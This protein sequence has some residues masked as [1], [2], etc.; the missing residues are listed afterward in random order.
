M[1]TAMR[2]RAKTPVFSIGQLESLRQDRD[3]D[4]A[5]ETPGVEV[6]A[7]QYRALLESRMS[8][9][10]DSH[11][12]PPP[13]R[14][15]E[16]AGVETRRNSAGELQLDKTTGLLPDGSPASDGT[17]VAFDEETVYFKPISFSPEPPSPTHTHE[18][19]P[20]LSPSTSQPDNLSLQIC[21]D[22]LTRELASGMTE[23]P[24][25]NGSD[26]LALQIW[27][28]IEAYER[29]RDQLLDARL[30]QDELQPL[31]LM[32][33]MWLRA[34][35]TI[36]DTLTGGSTISDDGYEMLEAEALD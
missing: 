7:E 29:V 8:M 24:Q 25:R 10:T 20:I 30:R 35:Y 23:R 14:G 2:R 32:F 3:F 31:E 33:D 19:I 18:F 13:S 11:S 6:L 34:L 4:D 5:E 22:L 26:V 21:L 12:E 27:V 9:L 1:S 15:G 28:M 17:L 36:H 16:Q